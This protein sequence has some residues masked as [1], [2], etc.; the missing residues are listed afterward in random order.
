MCGVCALSRTSQA[1]PTSGRGEPIALGRAPGLGAPATGLEACIRRR[2]RAAPQRSRRTHRRRRP[3]RCL[4]RRRAAGWPRPEA[5]AATLSPRS[6]GGTEAQRH[7]ECRAKPS[8]CQGDEPE[9]PPTGSGVRSRHAPAAEPPTERGRRTPGGEVWPA[10][11][12]FG[13]GP[14]ARSGAPSDARRAVRSPAHRGTCRT[15]LERADAAACPSCV[16]RQSARKQSA[17]GPR[18]RAEARA[19]PRANRQ[20]LQPRE[21]G[22][23]AAVPWVLE[24]PPPQAEGTAP[25]PERRAAM[26]PARARRPRRPARALGRPS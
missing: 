12:R 13:V 5:R 22:Q 1:V 7:D 8:G 17:S 11:E 23:P 26:G 9:P 24:L 2:A 3:R 4:P 14:S 6:S 18:W 21:P 20:R 15:G 19:A 10:A 16:P 25:P